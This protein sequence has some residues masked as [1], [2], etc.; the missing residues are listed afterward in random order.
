MSGPM[1]SVLSVASVLA[2]TCLAFG[3]RSAAP[4]AKQEF[5]TAAEELMEDEAGEWRCRW[6][7][8]DANGDVTYSVEGT[9]RLT[10]IFGSRVLEVVTEVPSLQRK[11]RGLKFIDPNLQQVIHVSVAS[12]GDHWVLIHDPETHEVLSQPH[13]NADGTTSIIRFRPEE[14]DEDYRRIVMEHSND[15]GKTWAR[16]F[17]ETMER[18]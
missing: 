9:E 17:I 7:Y 8:L 3:S 4:D 12:D 2:F 13:R 1:R 10:P 6:E 14:H 18:R 16:G 15:G 11:S 5:L